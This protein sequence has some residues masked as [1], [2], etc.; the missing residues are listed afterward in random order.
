MALLAISTGG[1]DTK[2]ALVGKSIIQERWQS[3][4]DE[5]EK[6]MPQIDRLL[7]RAGM[8]FADLKEVLA[9]KG[10][11]SFTGLRVG[12]TVAN[13]IAYLTGSKL[14]GVNSFSY[15]WE[16]FGKSDPE[17]AL[18]IFAGKGGLYVSCA[19]DQQEELVPLGEIN[20]YIGSRGIKKVFGPIS[21]EQKMEIA[22]ADFIEIEENFGETILR[23]LRQN[24]SPVK[25]IE[26]LYVKKP[27]ITERKKA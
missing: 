3:V 5:A 11:G 24:L 8:N 15:W 16:V 10:P 13:T 27:G 14:Y 22:G 19:K 9:I 7:I 26:P 23:I 20:E 2:I 17:T 6:L 18:L 1:F 25:I 12:V 21:D 4:N